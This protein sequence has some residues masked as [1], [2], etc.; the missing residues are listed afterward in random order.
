MQIKE[1]M[2][3]AS[4]NEEKEQLDSIGYEAR[5]EFELAQ[6]DYKRLPEEAEAWQVGEDIRW[7]YIRG[8]D[9]DFKRD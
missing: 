8:I 9:N 7:A 3:V 6:E 5:R 4:S 2:Q 1:R